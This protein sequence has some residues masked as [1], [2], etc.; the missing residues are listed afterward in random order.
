[1]LFLI[2]P[3]FFNFRNKEDENYNKLQLN[4]LD[5]RYIGTVVSDAAEDQMIDNNFVNVRTKAN[6][7][8][9]IGA[10][11][12][13]TERNMYD[14]T[15]IVVAM[16]YEGYL[17]P[18]N[19]SNVRIRSAFTAKYTGT[20]TRPSNWPANVRIV[21]SDNLPELVEG[22]TNILY[23]ILEPNS[24]MLFDQNHAHHVERMYITFNYAAF[25]EESDKISLNAHFEIN[26]E[27]TEYASAECKRGGLTVTCKTQKNRFA[28]TIM[29]NLRAKVVKLKNSV[30]T[31]NMPYTIADPTP[32]KGTKRSGDGN[33][34]Y[35]KKSSYGNKGGYQKKSYD[36]NRSGGYKKP[37][38]RGNQRRGSVH[39]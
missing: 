32:D 38:D 12:Y 18:F 36:N 39:Y 23:M 22:K 6:D 31:L 27:V 3:Q 21:E 8:G 19:F 33:R 30:D 24:N 20:T 4:A 15:A 11:I 2:N 14:G 26:L 10:A 5:G 34:G 25:D 28:P 7:D 16:P 29:S 17:I 35:D 37:F 1:M 13:A 9:S